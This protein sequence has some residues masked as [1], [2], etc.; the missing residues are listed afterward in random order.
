VTTF[1]EDLADEL[2]SK[3]HN[4]FKSILV[5]LPAR[6][7]ALFL[8]RALIVRLNNEATW[9]PEIITM[10]ELLSRMTGM[11]AADGIDALFDLFKVFRERIDPDARFEPFLQWGPMA[12]A[13]FNEI[14]HNLQSA[15]AVFKNLNDF[16]DIEAWS[17]GDDEEAWSLAQRNFSNFWKKLGQLYQLYAEHQAQNNAWYGGA[18]AREAGIQSIEKFKT[19]GREHVYIA[20][21][22]AL[23]KAERRVI[24]QLSQAK[25]A[26]LRWDADAYY[27]TRKGSEAGHFMRDYKRDQLLDELPD[28]F[29]KHPKKI[30]FAGCSGTITQMQYVAQVLE[31]VDVAE[32]TQTAVILP[33][34]AVLPVLL[35][36]LPKK[37][38]EVN[39]TM[40]RSLSHTPYRSLTN[41]FFRLLENRSG[42]IRYAVLL[43]FLR[44]PFIS[45]NKGNIGSTFRY[46]AEQVIA[47]NTVVVDRADLLGYATASP[48]PSDEVTQFIDALYDTLRDRTPQRI[49]AALRLLQRATQPEENSALETQQ[50]WNLLVALTARIARLCAQH[51]VMTEVREFERIY[52]KLFNQLQIDL[53]GEPLSGLQIMGLLESRALDFKRVIIV[54]ANEG[55]LPRNIPLESFLPADL[56]AGLQLPSVRERDAYYAYYFYRLLQ[57]A[58]EIHLVYN[59]GENTHDKGEKSRYIQQLETCEVLDPQVVERTALRVIARNEANAPALPPIVTGEFTQT[60]IH[61]L[62]KAGLSPSA[63]NKWLENP[64]EFFFNYLLQLGELEDIE[65]E[66][67]HSTI[68]T[69]V[70][71]IL[72]KILEPFV[73]LALRADDLVQAKQRLDQYLEEALNNSRKVHLTRHGVNYIIRKVALSI[74]DKLLSLSIDEAKDNEVHI[75]SLEA[76]FN[77]PLSDDLALKGTADRIDRFNGQLRVIDYKTGKA[78]PADLEFKHTW[79]ESMREGKSPKILQTLLYA[80]I[81]ARKTPGSNPVAGIMSPRAFSAGFMPVKEK[82]VLVQMTPEMALEFSEWLQ[83]TIHELCEEAKTFPYDEKAKYNTYSVSLEK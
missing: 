59:A 64:R 6:R 12:L 39:V 72:E 24:K 10:S 36:T 4:A 56:R 48:K 20:G 23:S 40:G 51:P 13:D 46:I 77:E 27:V 74:T 42:K 79:K 80:F 18:I 30:T 60:Q 69:L 52:Q 67:E 50:G 58:E 47:R 25:L 73:G 1:I 83:T 43:P 11:A 54:N 81:S 31:T 41:A 44:H 9:L 32:A 75:V 53:V 8:K 78:N 70:H 71:E 82:D 3:H 68:G 19:L 17:F 35:P 14:D 15:D 26:T 38:T 63:I 49:I 76:K 21:L 37:F 55:T 5:V 45:G 57:R 22:N 34:N 16:K 62:L 33:D 61:R 65:E 29:A 28:H 7:S 2:V 66:M